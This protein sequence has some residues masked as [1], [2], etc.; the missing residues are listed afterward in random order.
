M[1]P[2][3]DH[4]NDFP[5]LPKSSMPC[6]W[7]QAGLLTYRICDWNYECERC[8]LDAAMRGVAF[9]PAVR[10]AA[11]ADPPA[12]T[13]RPEI[14]GDRR[15]HPACGW[16]AAAGEGRLRWGL[17]AVTAHLLDRITSVVLPASGTRLEQGRIASWLVD[18]GELVPLRAPVSGTVVHT[19]QAAQR[20]PALVTAS[21]YE[22]GWLVEL[23]NDRRLEEVP[24][25]CDAEARAESAA[26]Q[27][28]RLRDAARRR[29]QG[30]PGVGP[31][32]ADGGERITDLRRMLG[33]RRY[34][35]LVLSILR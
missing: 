17:D 24:G 30:V 25:L 14:P 29:L 8:P 21:P 12:P 3:P 23:E 32:A 34:H 35:R 16:V 10:E 18:G 15:Y 13:P 2:A 28:E 7:M 27:M 26:R 4:E 5:V 22:A 6:V 19:N 31:T 11:G 1:K 9:T 33:A 20:D